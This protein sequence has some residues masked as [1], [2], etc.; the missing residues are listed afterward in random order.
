MDWGDRAGQCPAGGVAVLEGWGG[1]G[2]TLQLSC[3]FVLGP[4]LDLP[5]QHLCN[6]G[7][8]F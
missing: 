2:G 7:R 1:Q 8:T 4:E 5:S 3:G 6:S